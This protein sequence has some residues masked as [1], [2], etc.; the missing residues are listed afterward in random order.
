MKNINNITALVPV[1]ANSDRIPRKNIRN[2]L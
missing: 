2:V 1:I